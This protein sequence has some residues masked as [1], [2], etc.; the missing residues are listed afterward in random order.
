MKVTLALTRFEEDIRELVVHTVKETTWPKWKVQAKEIIQPERSIH[1]RLA[2][3]R[4]LTMG[5]DEA[6]SDFVNRY[7]ITVGR[8]GIWDQMSEEQKYGDLVQRTTPK[9]R[10]WFRKDTCHTYLEAIKSIKKREEAKDDQVDITESKKAASVKIPNFAQTVLTVTCDN[11]GKVGHSIEKCWQVKDNKDQY[12]TSD[13]EYQVKRLK[14]QLHACRESQE[15]PE[16]AI[17]EVRTPEAP[18]TLEGRASRHPLK[19]WVCGGPHKQHECTRAGANNFRACSKCGQ[20]GHTEHECTLRVC[21]N[22]HAVGHSIKQCRRGCPRC[23]MFNHL[24]RD[25]REVDPGGFRGST[26]RGRGTYRGT[27]RGAHAN[28]QRGRG[29]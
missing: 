12:P 25:H 16:A 18:R 17:P 13:L 11:C 14:Q 5:K 8:L 6:A 22:C 29:T 23:G 7:I 1:E 19:C 20:P 4:G 3:V 21:D 15:A 10:S 2:T 24:T 27:Y 9:I 28:T 26:F